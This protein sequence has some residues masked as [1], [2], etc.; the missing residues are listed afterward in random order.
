MWTRRRLRFSAG[1][2]AGVTTWTFT[3]L[4]TVDSEVTRRR[5]RSAGRPRPGD[6]AEMVFH[7]SSDAGTALQL[8]LGGAPMTACISGLTVVGTG[9]VR[10][11]TSSGAGAAASDR[12]SDTVD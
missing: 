2:V 4:M 3:P 6:G 1:I 5:S 7:S 11:G 8:A 12:G 10:A 9:I